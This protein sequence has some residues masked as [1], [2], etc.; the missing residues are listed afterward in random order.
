MWTIDSFDNRKFPIEW[1]TFKP[2]KICTWFCFKYN[3]FSSKSCFHWFGLYTNQQV[4]HFWWLL[5]FLWLL[6]GSHH[7]WYIELNVYCF[8]I[9]LLFLPPTTCIPLIESHK[10]VCEETTMIS[11]DNIS[12]EICHFILSKHIKYLIVVIFLGKVE[13]LGIKNST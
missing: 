8:V 13:H 5:T 2:M 1:K 4:I 3:C 9:I 11:I 12:C 7:L 10:V 6:G